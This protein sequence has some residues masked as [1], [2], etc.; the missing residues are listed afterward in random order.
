MLALTLAA[1]LHVKA[2]CQPLYDYYSYQKA[3][4]AYEQCL[5]DWHLSEMQPPCK[6]PKAVDPPAEGV[7]PS[8]CDRLVA[9]CKDQHLW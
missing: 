5:W 8:T 3:W 7:I 1:C 6:E 2:V 4:A 9:L